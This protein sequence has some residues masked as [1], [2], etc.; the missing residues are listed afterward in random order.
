MATLQIEV[1]DGDK[2]EGCNHIIWRRDYCYC[3][4]FSNYLT[5][6]DEEL[7]KNEREA[8]KLSLCLR[9]THTEILEPWQIE[10]KTRIEEATTE[11]RDAE[12]HLWSLKYQCLPHSYKNHVC[13]IC[14][15]PE[16]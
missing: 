15:E 16:A 2:C 7:A 10:L 4:V 9:E 5:T 13:Q 8:W 6:C 3:S 1:P 11:F 14:G 12:R